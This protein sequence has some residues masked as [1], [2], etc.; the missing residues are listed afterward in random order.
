MKSTISKLLS[1]PKIIVPI[2][3]VVAIAIG[4]ATYHLVGRAPIVALPSSSSPSDTS[5]ATSD[6]S[7]NLSFTVSGRVVQLAVKAGDKVTK[8]E[9]LASLDGGTAQGTLNQAK[10]ALELAESQYA[11]LDLQYQNAKTQQDVLVSNAYNTLL[12]SSLQARSIGQDDSNAPVI[13]GTYTCGKEGS[14]EIDPYVSG[15]TSSYSFNYSGLETG[16]QIASTSA[17]EPLGTCGLFIQFTPGFYTSTKWTIAIPNTTSSSYV[18]NKNAYDLAVTTRDQVLSQLAANLG[19]G[20]TSDA[21][22]AK[23][24][25]D[26]AEGAYQTALAAY[27]NTII[28]SPVDGTVSFIDPDLKVGQVVTPNKPIISITTQ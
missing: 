13:T 21:N 16:A 15:S 24:A 11:S 22:V 19:Q 5:A 10:G 26:S 27:D 20:G 17:P 14:Y 4:A 25:V 18:A 12:S 2:V 6:L 3:A 8:G 7:T 9:T 28:T 23:A 1:R